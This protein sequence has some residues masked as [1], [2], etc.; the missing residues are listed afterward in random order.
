M[1]S[2]KQGSAEPSTSPTHD[3]GAI[4]RCKKSTSSRTDR[5]RKPVINT[6]A[7]FPFRVRLG[8]DNVRMATRSRIPLKANVIRPK[9]TQVHSWT[10]NQDYR[11][12]QHFQCPCTT[13]GLVFELR[14]HKSQFRPSPV[15]PAITNNSDKVNMDRVTRV[16]ATSAIVTSSIGANL[17]GFSTAQ[18][19]VGS[20][21]LAPVCVF[22]V[23]VYF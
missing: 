7:A 3:P 1:I 13:Y 23:C 10:I 15:P 21:P 11:P 12:G 19:S 9:G 2:V 22:D 6:T 14:Y 8:F 16:R 20:G 5:F 18:G 4:S 17:H